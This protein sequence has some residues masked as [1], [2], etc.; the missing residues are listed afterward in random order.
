MLDY[1]HFIDALKRKPQAF[2][3]L[4]FRDALFPRDAYRRTWEQLELQLPQRRACQTI[5]ALLEMAARDGVEGALAQRLE[6]LLVMG[7][8]PDLQR[9]R[10]EF[11]PRI[12]ELPQ[13]TV[14]IPPASIY[15]LLLPSAQVNELEE[16]AA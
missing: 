15:D 2:K 13:I 16:V 9:L 12:P 5:I 10:E 11:A 8:L 3:G 7:E 14:E 4:L 6:A 1:R